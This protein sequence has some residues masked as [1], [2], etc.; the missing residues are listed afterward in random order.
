LIRD[1]LL[2]RHEDT[3]TDAVRKRHTWASNT[4]VKSKRPMR[5]SFPMLSCPGKHCAV[6]RY[7]E[8]ERVDVRETSLLGHVSKMRHSRAEG[9]GS[10]IRAVVPNRIGEISGER[11]NQDLVL[12]EF[13]DDVGKPPVTPT[14]HALAIRGRRPWWGTGI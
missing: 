1:M 14:L 11:I 2:F 5:R 6:R 13:E 12:I 3:R 9:H 8:R 7:A 10:Q 4:G